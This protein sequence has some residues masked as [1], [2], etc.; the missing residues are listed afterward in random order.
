MEIDDQGPE[1]SEPTI[2]YDG[3]EVQPLVLKKTDKEIISNLDLKDSYS[4]DLLQ[5]KEQKINIVSLFCGAGGMDLGVELSGLDCLIGEEQVNK[6]I[7]DKQIF[8]NHRHEGLFHHVYS[9]DIS[10]DA[11]E[12]YSNNFPKDTFV[13][14]CDIRH[15]KKFPKADLVLGWFPCPFLSVTNLRIKSD[16]QN[17]LYLHYIRCLTQ[18]SPKFFIAETAKGILTPNNGMIFRQI[19]QDFE[20]AGYKVYYKLLNAR[21]YGVPQ[22]RERVFFIGV[23]EDIEFEYEFPKESHGVDRPYVTLRDTINDLKC[24]PGEYFT[25]GFSSV[26]MSRNRKKK[27]EDQSFTIQGSASLAPLH[28]SGHPMKKINIK[29]WDFSDLKE[30]NRRLSV[31]ELKRIHTFPDWY[32]FSDGYKKS[33]KLISTN[34]RLEKIYRQI[35]NAVPIQLSRAIAKPIAQWF[36]KNQGTGEKNVEQNLPTTNVL[37]AFENIL[38]SQK[39]N[40]PKV[41]EYNT[42]NRI[43]KEG[44]LF[45]YYVKDA[46][47]GTSFNLEN[48]ELKKNQYSKHFSYIGNSSN[49]PDLMIRFGPAVEV[50][51]IDNKYMSKISLN[52]SFPKDFLYCDD[53]SINKACKECEFENFGWE[54]KE[55]IYVIGN[56]ENKSIINLWFIYGDCYSADKEIYLNLTRIIKEGLLAIPDVDFGDTKEIGRVKTADPLGRAQLRVRPMWEIP[57]PGSIYKDIVD[58]LGNLNLLLREE[59]YEEIQDRP[60][61][62]PFIESGEL[63][64]FKVKIPDPNDAV[65]RI[66]AILFT[67]H[68]ED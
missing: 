21:D 30:R 64:I 22:H 50:K 38:K 57:H 52:S 6:L 34:L 19:K 48:T 54:K 45:E 32:Q 68:I 31:N 35:G 36:Y 2:V 41:T 63:R 56:T 37:K 20:A 67:A 28:P 5:Y 42:N 49:P 40:L 10:E 9:N 66:D 61:F 16:P 27:W 65:K 26:Y 11:L 59:T 1:K 23:R 44:D 18:V 14:N 33:G 12:T 47:C 53:P 17:T 4:N 13:H 51:K 55:M 15:I 62:E 24:N 7:K 25:G 39:L 43:N 60:N 8:N 46:F 3:E 58:N 29:R